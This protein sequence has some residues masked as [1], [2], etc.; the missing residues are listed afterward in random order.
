[1]ARHDNGGCGCLGLAALSVALLSVL[2]WIPF[3][4]AAPTYIGYLAIADRAQ[5]LR[6]ETTWW[7]VLAA[8]PLLGLV[9]V[10]VASGGRANP[11]QYAERTGA[12]LTAT[13]L[14]SAATLLGA[15]FL[16][17]SALD[18]PSLTFA[19]CVG[20]TL[21]LL[22][23]LIKWRR[24]DR[25][26]PARERVEPVTVEQV[27]RVTAQ[28]Q[29]TL[30][31]VRVEN[32]RI[33][34]LSRAIEA[35]LASA[36][37][38]MDFEGLRQMHRESRGCADRAY[39]HYHSAGDILRTMS[40]THAGVRVALRRFA[41]PTR[42]RKRPDRLAY[43]AATAGLTA[44]ENALVAQVNRGGDMVDTLNLRTAA[45]KYTIRDECG[46]H[47]QRWYSDLELRIEA[48]QAARRQPL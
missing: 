13:T 11:R 27:R 5:L 22:A 43:A 29:E 23:L 36:R 33:E 38:E 10:V 4:L 18:P 39:Q 46:A 25:S 1:M 2:V 20:S 34:R 16:H 45:L 42:G 7:V 32:D 26:H 35:K 12:L 15:R 21:A 9:L 19:P 30:R 44:T 37:S 8:A 48:A 6:D 24:G 17:G 40:R 14:T 31:R 28:A 41:M 3:V 47:G